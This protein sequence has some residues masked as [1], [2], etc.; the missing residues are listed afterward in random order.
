MKRLFL[1]L[2]G[3]IA[4]AQVPAKLPPKPF[5]N[6]K[7]L[8]RAIPYPNS[9]IIFAVQETAPK[10]EA[11]WQR[12]ENAAVAIAEAAR[13]MLLPG[14]LRSDGK[15]APVAS[16][17]WQKFTV[18]M[19]TSAAVCYKAAQSRNQQA[20]ADCTDALSVS[21]SNCHDVYRDRKPAR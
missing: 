20:V 13:L 8:M 21:C 9:D 15:P 1:L 6:V 17:D 19:S 3:A 4:A 12:V 10:D 7:Q 18:Q 5:G 11:E 14:R 16:V 2:S